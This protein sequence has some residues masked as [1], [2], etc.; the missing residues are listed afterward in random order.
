M[1]R[2]IA[3]GI[4]ACFLLSLIPAMTLVSNSDGFTIDRP[5]VESRIIPDSELTLP[6]VEALNSIGMGRATNSNWSATGGSDSNDEIY[7]MVFDSQGNVIICGSI[8]Q[9]SQFGSIIVNTEGEGDI[10]MA[11]LSKTGSWVW[12]VSAGTALYYDE[13]RGVTVDSNDNIYGTGYFRGEVNFGNTTISTTG[14]DGWIAR[15]NSTGQFDWAMKFGGFD[16]D[17]GWDI[18]ADNYDNLYVTGYYQNF[19]EFDSSLLEAQTYSENARFFIAYYNVTSSLWDW[20]KDSDGTGNSVPYQIVVEPS[21]NAAYAAGYHTGT[22]TWNNSFVSSPQSTYA[23]FVVKYSEDGD[24]IWGQ[25]SAGSTCFGTNCGVYFNNIV[26][27]PDGGI[28]V[29]GNFL[30]TFKKQGGTVVTGQGSWDVLLLR[31]DMNGTQLWDYNAGGSDDDRLQ[32]LSVNLKGQVQFGGTQLAEMKFGSFTLQKNSST[33]YYDSFI[34]QI[35]FDSDFQWA[36]SLGG[37]GNDTVGGLL[38][39]DDGSLIAGGDFSGTVWFGG[40]PRTATEQDIFVWKFQHDK[41]DDGVTDYTDNCLNTPNSNQSNFDGDLRG[42]ACDSDDDNDGLHDVLDDCQYGEIDWNQSNTSYDHDSDGCKDLEE[43]NDDDNDGIT[44]DLDNCPSGHLDWVL[45][46]SSDMDGDGCRDSDE[47]T[48]D[49][50][51]SV[52]DT[53]DN[54]QY[55][56]NQLQVDYDENGVGDACDPDDDG[57]GIDDLVDDCYQGSLNWTSEV[58]TD[59]DGDGCE[60]ENSNEDL[61]DDNDGI[62]DVDDNCPRGEIGWNSSQ[63]NDRDGDGCRNDNEDNDNDNDS[64][65]N[66]VDLC[67]NGIANWRKNASNDN[68]GDGCIDDR[69]DSDDDNDGF[70]DLVDFCPLQ[71]GTATLGGMKGCPD[72]DSDGWA[73]AVDAFFQD[74]TQWNDGDGDGYGDNPSGN[75]PDDCPFFFGNSSGDRIGCIDSD[76]DGYSDPELSWSVAQGADAFVDEPSQWADADGDGYGDN[77]DGE[78]V[79]FCTNKEGTSTIDRYGCPDI[80]GD[81][82]SDSDAFW[83]LNKWDS[84][85]YGPDAFPI[86]PTQWYD[87]DQDGFG[88]N[89]GNPEWNESRDPSWPGIF[90][91]NATSADMCPFEVPDG[92]FDDDVNYPGCLLTEPSDGGKSTDDGASSVSDDGMSTTT[93]IGIIGGV[94]VLLL[95][96]VIAVMLKKKPQPKK[97]TSAPQALTDLPMP[98]PPGPQLNLN[99]STTNNDEEEKLDSDDEPPTADSEQNV[100]TETNDEGTEDEDTVE[101]WEGLPAGDYLDPDENG[102][103]WFRANDGDNWYQN[104]DESWTKW[105]D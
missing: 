39:L 69:E 48:D 37:A 35:D 40:T 102:T 5:E 82:Y 77:F 36:M 66:E 47:D 80:D 38:A 26:M 79:D 73:D 83:G 90:V 99:N 91:E 52:L 101:S 9:V 105:K 100:D 89:W 63:T 84:L 15:V 62:F 45:D 74:E 27:H 12:A 76:G 49:D 87:S 95:L 51:D 59:K 60:D 78:M 71:E 55:T 28:V 42:D 43:D 54:C 86:D 88:D 24:F 7:E 3:L 20:A 21:T 65:I 2:L 98:A 104:A 92:R 61:D 53:E 103:V 94:V 31:Y 22:E 57:D 85:G 64:V 1:R 72:F 30:Q 23:G 70:S 67:K 32:A 10:L 11:K 19:T 18:A 16:I 29:G 50:G 14:F 97:K 81:G 34:A 25:N 75:N 58:Q 68:D 4:L 56:V 13:C 6:Q 96:G 33:M 8:Y 93:L 41:D 17:V 46:S 44:D